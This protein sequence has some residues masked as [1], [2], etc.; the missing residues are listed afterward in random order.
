MP[1]LLNKDKSKEEKE[2]Q[3]TTERIDRHNYW[4]ILIREKDKFDPVGTIRLDKSEERLE[5]K[6]QMWETI[7]L[8]A[9]NYD[10]QKKS[11]LSS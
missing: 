1:E 6:I 9:N 4:I 11:M 2:R 8:W 3:Y 7:V 10:S 5:D